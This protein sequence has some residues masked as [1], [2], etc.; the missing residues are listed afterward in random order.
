MKKG[1]SVWAF[2]DRTPD[3]C[4]PL[5]KQCGYDGVEVAIGPEGP[6]RFDST[7]AEMKELRKK[8]EAYG[9]EFYS[10]VCD[11]CWDYSISASD[12]AERKKAEDIIIRQLEVASYLGCDTILALAGMVKSIK[13]GGEIVPYDVAYERAF[14]SVCHLAKYAQEYKVNL[15]IENVGNK[16]LLSPLETRDFI[17][18]VGNPWVKQYFDVGNVIKNGYPN[19]W[20]DIL[21][22]R[23]AKVHFKDVGLFDGAFRAVNILEGLVDYDAVMHSLENAGYND[24]VTAEVF[25][26]AGKTENDVELL[27]VN[28]KAMDRILGRE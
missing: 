23:I 5:A 6:I 28:S 1:I 9:I 24:W 2:K 21:G 25:P 17:D 10:L 26:A 14:E 13:A 7:E 19:H 27:M 8:A 16:L 15:A 4:F 18:K 3:V 12:P 11:I 20:I 22:K